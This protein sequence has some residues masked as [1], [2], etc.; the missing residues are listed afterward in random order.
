MVLNQYFKS[1]KLQDHTTAGVQV[2]VVPLP[3][4]P[5]V[6]LQGPPPPPGGFLLTPPT[7]AAELV[8]Y[9]K[10][11]GE[12]QDRVDEIVAAFTTAPTRSNDASSAASSR[13]GG[14]GLELI[15]TLQ[16][17]GFDTFVTDACI[18]VTGNGS[19]SVNPN[20]KQLGLRFRGAQ[21]GWLAAT[22]L[23]LDIKLCEACGIDRSR[24]AQFGDRVVI[25][26]SQMMQL[27]A[28]AAPA[29]PPQGARR[30]VAGEEQAKVD[31][32]LSTR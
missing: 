22:S 12:D 18:A 29:G 21:N 9:D 8:G 3:Y 23:G 24:F 19:Y 7:T 1:V 17:P 15:L 16:P 13:S 25:P 30:R 14:R 11:R 4:C 2:A 5:H 27:P 20:L 10:L 32:A 31:A 6:L 26:V 28:V